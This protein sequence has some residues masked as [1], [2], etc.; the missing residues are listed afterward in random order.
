MDRGAGGAR[1]I[2]SGGVEDGG[3]LEEVDEFAAIALGVGA[4]GGGGPVDDLLESDRIHGGVMAQTNLSKAT[5]SAAARKCAFQS[6]GYTCFEED[7]A[8]A[9]ALRELLDKKLIPVPK[10]YTPQEYDS[11]INKSI[12][13]YYPEYWTAHKRAAAKVEKAA[14]QSRL[15]TERDTR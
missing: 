6:R 12:E 1:R 10:E 3:V 7:C 4:G 2:S 9:V 13:R 8:A 14:A 11:C 5:F 15:F